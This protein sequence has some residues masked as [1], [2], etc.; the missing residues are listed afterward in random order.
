MPGNAI[1]QFTKNGVVGSALATAANTSSMG[2]G[3]IETDIFKVL[4][5]GTDGT[6]VEFVRFLAVATT[7]TNT[8]AT[9]GRVFFSSVT[10]GATTSANTFLVAEIPLPVSAADNAA[11]ALN[12]V[13]VAINCRLPAGFALLFTTHAAPVANTNWRATAFGGDY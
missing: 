13:D 11:I 6:F 8:T 4:T 7:P 5:A 10:S 12:P 3:T 2:T 1:P 9:I